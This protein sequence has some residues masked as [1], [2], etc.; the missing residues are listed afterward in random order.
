MMMSGVYDIPRIS[1]GAKMVATN[2]TPVGAFRGAGRPEAAFAIERIMDELS[3]E[4]GIDP[5]E[6]RR[7]NFIRPGAFPFTTK[8]GVTYD[9]GAYE[10]T[11][12]AA[13]EAAGYDRLRVEQ[14]R[15]IEAGETT[16]LGIG[17]STYVELTNLFPATENVRLELATDGS[18]TLYAGSGPTGQG[19]QTSWA[20]IA[21]SQLG[22]P[23]ERIEVVLGDTDRVP[24]GGLTGG[25]RSLQTLGPVIVAASSQLTEL[26]K[27]HAATALEAAVEDIVFDQELGTF[28][29]AGTPSVSVDWTRV[30]EIAA[31]GIAAQLSGNEGAAGTSF[32]FGAHVAVVE[33]D[34]ET[35]LVRLVRFVA[36][37]D[38]GRVINPLLVEGQVH[39]GVASGVAQALIEEIVY[40]KDGN[41]QTSTFADYGI[42]SAAELPS[43]ELVT[44]ETL[45]PL[46]PL[47]AKG[48]G[49]SGTTGSPPAVANAVIDALAHLG[50]RHIDIPM[51]PINVWSAL[52]RYASATTS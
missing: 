39:G 2:T 32:P 48:I 43:F 29:V 21:S 19:H 7:R 52:Q 4:L 11:L 33:V 16:L 40:D 18:V 12:D 30:A 46:N 8:T 36:V 10:V 50:I 37:D 26:A 5:A 28:S 38:C 23:M 13:L 25:S 41:P 42:I 9:S 49:E 3:D 31:A 22:I 27:E 6:L 35:G 45:T 47:G 15:R 24:E 44:T 17:L 1:F 14:R 20:M 34:R 51:T